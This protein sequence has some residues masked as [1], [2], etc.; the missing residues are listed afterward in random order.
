MIAAGI[1]AGADLSRDV[2]AAVSGLTNGLQEAGTGLGIAAGDSTGGGSACDWTSVLESF[3]LASQAPLESGAASSTPSFT[4]PAS[5]GKEQ[6]LLAQR[7]M[8]QTPVHREPAAMGRC[9]SLHA[10]PQPGDKPGRSEHAGSGFERASENAGKKRE[11]AHAPAAEFISDTTA[12]FNSAAIPVSSRP[13]SPSTIKPEVP[14]PDSILSGAPGEAISGIDGPAKEPSPHSTLETQPAKPGDT[15]GRMGQSGADPAPPF[16]KGDDAGRMEKLHPGAT[17]EA[18]AG[19]KPASGRMDHDA[20]TPAAPRNAGERT[21]SN[22]AAAGDSTPKAP[23]VSPA[24]HGAPEQAPISP[25]LVKEQPAR[26]DHSPAKTSVAQTDSSV[27]PAE[28]RESANNFR[29]GRVD[30]KQNTKAARQT[31]ADASIVD[32]KSPGTTASDLPGAVPV[33]GVDANPGSGPS[34]ESAPVRSPGQS[35]GPRETF[36]ALDAMPPTAW[37]HT[38]ARRAE[39]GYFDPALGWVGIRAEAVGSGFHAAVTPGSA[40]AAQVLGSHLPGLNAWLSEHHGPSATVTMADFN[41]GQVGSGIDQGSQSEPRKD[42]RETSSGASQ[43][44]PAAPK[45]AG[46]IS[47]ASAGVALSAFPGDAR[48][49]SVVA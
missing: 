16:G 18:I 17:P 11:S 4:V 6:V 43:D 35:P 49:I 13:P 37:L 20:E 39:A 27:G 31:G 44:S 29:A 32:G 21:A 30:Q 15:P 7:G 28:H 38:G 33:R 34:Q 19:P 26:P 46:T 24:A 48:Y 42:G 5:S 9:S 47:T 45:E 10:N 22:S 14:V 12:S 36:A 1:Q 40:E 3:A 2:A 8:R 25:G 23:V 41:H